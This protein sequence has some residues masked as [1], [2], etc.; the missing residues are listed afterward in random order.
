[1]LAVPNDA[2]EVFKQVI[3]R[4]QHVLGLRFPFFVA[5]TSD[6]RLLLLAFRLE[7]PASVYLI[8]IAA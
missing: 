6:F 7:L 8:N 3:E 2:G 4:P 1:M 5:P